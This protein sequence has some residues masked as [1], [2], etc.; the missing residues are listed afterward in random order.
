[1]KQ[2]REVRNRIT[3]IQAIDFFF[4]F[5]KVGSQF[6]REK[7]VFSVNYAGLIGYHTGGGELLYI[8]PY[9]KIN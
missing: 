6:G 4:F 1:M 3:Q 9:R 7:I 8:P 5:A 2:N